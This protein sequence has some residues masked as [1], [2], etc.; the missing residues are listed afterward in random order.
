MRTRGVL[1]NSQFSGANELVERR[2]GAGTLFGGGHIDERVG[3]E[4]KALIHLFPERV[5][6]LQFDRSNVRE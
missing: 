6:Q 1:D 4:F 3:H 2:F 5:S